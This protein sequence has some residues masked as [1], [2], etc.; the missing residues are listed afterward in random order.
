MQIQPVGMGMITVLEVGCK[1]F[2]VNKLLGLYEYQSFADI[3]L[4]R[5]NYKRGCKGLSFREKSCVLDADE[6]LD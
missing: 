2:M 3:D 1:L 5:K 4:T 6:I